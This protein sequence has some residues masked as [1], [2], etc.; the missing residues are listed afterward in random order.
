MRTVVD[1]GQQMLEA[2]K[3]KY[4]SAN[5]FRVN[6]RAVRAVTYR[7][8]ANYDAV[9]PSGRTFRQVEMRF[10]REF[11]L[12]SMGGDSSSKRSKQ[13]FALRLRQELIARLR[14]Q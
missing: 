2:V 5:V 13:R 8:G 6:R 9:W 10:I 3:T 7:N 1:V 11:E 12:T 14:A 4:D